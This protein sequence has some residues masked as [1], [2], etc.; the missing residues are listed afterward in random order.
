MN[1][2]QDGL[3]VNGSNNGVGYFLNEFVGNFAGNKVILW[4]LLPTACFFGGCICLLNVKGKRQVSNNAKQPPPLIPPIPPLVSGDK[5]KSI[6]TAT[7]I[8][9]KDNYNF[10]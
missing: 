3:A 4:V 10:L 7:Q 6:W 2:F 9:I 8:N 1:G 5:K